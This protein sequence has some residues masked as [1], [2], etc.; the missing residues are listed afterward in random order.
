MNFSPWIW[1][2]QQAGQ[3]LAPT[4]EIRET[5]IVA[6]RRDVESGDYSVEAE[7]VAEKIMKDHLLDLFS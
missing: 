1:E 3:I 2:I 6:L 5:K 4:L 7:Q